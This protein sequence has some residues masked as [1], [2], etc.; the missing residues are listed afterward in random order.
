MSRVVQRPSSTPPLYGRR[1]TDRPG[2]ESRL[3]PTVARWPLETDPEFEASHPQDPSVAIV[4]SS[5]ADYRAGRADRASAR[6]HDA[7]RWRVP[8]EGGGGGE[9]TG[10]EAIFGL[11]RDLARRTDGTFRQRLIALE[12]SRGPFVQA[13]VHTRASRD[14]RTLDMP[15]LIVFELSGDRISSVTEL[16]GDRA[17]WRAFWEG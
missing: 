4:H 12:G 17:A 15:S 9:W 1:S 16:P 3:A 13:H 7:I 5:I 10:P 14:G 2:G 8:V 11:H 6:W